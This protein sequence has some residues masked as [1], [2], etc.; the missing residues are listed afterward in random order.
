M[1]GIARSAHTSRLKRDVG[2]QS[3]KTAPCFNI[4]QP[5]FNGLAKSN[6][7]SVHQQPIV[8]LSWTAAVREPSIERAT[9]KE[10]PIVGWGKAL[11][12]STT[13]DELYDGKRRD[14]SAGREFHGA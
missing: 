9:P 8:K 5:L 6:R 10:S 4:A 2:R 11:L 13:R 7:N 3:T 1:K 14:P 12:V